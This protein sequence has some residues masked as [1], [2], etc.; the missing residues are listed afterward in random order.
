MEWSDVAVTGGGSTCWEMAYAG[1][2]SLALILVENQK[3]IV[4]FLH[5]SGILIPLGEYKD[6][7]SEKILSAIKF[8]ISDPEK[9]AQMSRKG[10]TLIDG[11]GAF[12][13]ADA[14]L[15]MHLLERHSVRN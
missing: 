11:Q 2:P 1:V 6:L 10:Q 3:G 5:S 9:R 15:K 13:V 8:L 12:R 4:E 14:L 7:T